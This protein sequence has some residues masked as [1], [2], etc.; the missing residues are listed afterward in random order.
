MILKADTPAGIFD[1][2]TKQATLYAVVKTQGDGETAIEL[3]LRPQA[4][5]NEAFCA[6]ALSALGNCPARLEE[7]RRLAQ[8]IARRFND[9]PK[10]GKR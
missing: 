1:I 5:S 7:T 8:E 2:D 4:A 6:A 9:Y 10:E 3:A